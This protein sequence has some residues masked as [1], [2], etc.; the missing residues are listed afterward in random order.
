MKHTQR[1]ARHKFRL[2]RKKFDAMIEANAR[3]R[4]QIAVQAAEHNRM[5]ACRARI[6]Y[7]IREINPELADYI[8]HGPSGCQLLRNDGY[9][10]LALP[11]PRN[12]RD[13]MQAARDA[14]TDLHENRTYRIV[15]LHV[16]FE[17][18]KEAM[19]KYLIVRIQGARRGGVSI[20]M[21]EYAFDHMSVQHLAKLLSEEVAA[22]IVAERKSSTYDKPETSR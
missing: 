16:D 11:A 7:V 10:I 14:L 2:S 4:W 20:G 22:C 18:V 21:S 17:K 13:F 1:K 8:A 19:S 15:G 12:I 9:D 5:Y 6:D 3:L